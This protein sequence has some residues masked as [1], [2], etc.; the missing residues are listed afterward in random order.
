VE[1]QVMTPSFAKLA[2]E[3]ANA[4]G[5]FESRPKGH[6]PEFRTLTYNVGE[7]FFRFVGPRLGAAELRV[8]QGLVGLAGPQNQRQMTRTD[9]GLIC[10]AHSPLGRRVTISTS[11]N[12]LARA[13]GY[14]AN[15]GSANAAIRKALEN[16]FM[17]AVFTG[18]A[19]APRSKD[20]AAGHLFTQLGSKEDGGR[21][22]VELCPLL[23]A[24]VLGGPGEY[25]RVSLNDVRKLAS[26]VA[27]L[28]HHRLHWVNPGQKREV[29]FTTMLDYVW[30]DFNV[31]A[32]TLRT[33][34]QVLRRALEE[35]VSI[36][37]TVENKGELHLIGRPAISQT[38]GLPN[39][40]RPTAILQT[41]TSRF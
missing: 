23:A 40:R 25:L 35:L 3:V 2:P 17:L 15:S 16:L 29:K 38:G 12:E 1:A 30:S 36:G 18:L 28:L 13:I 22:E 5:L 7:R 11:Y 33:R 8:L 32:S 39:R 26:D 19:D 9:D 4:P 10:Q 21:L 24:A 34:R 14:P 6:S 27:R 20:Y 41:G 37:W 31:S